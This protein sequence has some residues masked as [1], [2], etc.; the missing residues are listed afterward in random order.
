MFFS[1]V[2]L[3]SIQGASVH[4]TTSTSISQPSLSQATAF[5]QPT[6][7]QAAN[8]EAIPSMEAERPSTSSSVTG[9][10]DHRSPSNQLLPGPV[11]HSPSCLC[12]M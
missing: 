10:G 2:L 9:P 4:S 1:A 12:A 3:S 7:Q 6:Q 8:Q 5:V 11:F